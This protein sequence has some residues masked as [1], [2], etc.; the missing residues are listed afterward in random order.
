MRVLKLHTTMCKSMAQH[1]GFCRSLVA[2]TRAM[3]VMV[4][5]LEKGK[6]LGQSGIDVEVKR[7]GGTTTDKR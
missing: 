6:H 2:V 5:K 7:E 1:L 3:A 4:I